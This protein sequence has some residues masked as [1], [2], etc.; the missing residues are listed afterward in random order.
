[1]PPVTRLL[2]GA[3]TP[4][5]PANFPR[6]ILTPERRRAGQRHRDRRDP[7]AESLKAVSFNP[8]T[9]FKFMEDV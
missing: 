9:E 6:G 1:M 7:G 3:A 5:T 4:A 8:K 2:T